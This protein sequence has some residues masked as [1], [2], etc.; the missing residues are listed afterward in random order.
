MAGL[1]DSD[2][3]IMIDD[4]EAEQDRQYIQE[5]INKL[6]EAVSLIPEGSIREDQMQGDAA[7]ALIGRL[8]SA[9]KDL[10]NKCQDMGKTRVYIGEVVEHYRD[11]D[12]RLMTQIKGLMR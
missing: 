11:I 3:V 2:G 6:V 1:R 9:R 12:R 7:R 5:A 4:A 8:G 10:N